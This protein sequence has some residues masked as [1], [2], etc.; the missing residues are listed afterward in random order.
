MRRTVSGFGIRGLFGWGAGVSNLISNL[1]FQIS[2]YRQMSPQ[3]HRDHRE[4]RR[5]ERKKR[6]TEFTEKTPE[7]TESFA[8]TALLA[9]TEL[10]R[11][12]RR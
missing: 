1:K 2:D 7:G 12:L 3:R 5:G 6:N 10:P 11:G 9:E 8:S 4:T